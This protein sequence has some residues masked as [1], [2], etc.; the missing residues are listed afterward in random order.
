MFILKQIE[1]E[2]LKYVKGFCD[3]I[4]I[5]NAKNTGPNEFGIQEDFVSKNNIWCSRIG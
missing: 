2:V 5:L 4:K 1:I 3:L